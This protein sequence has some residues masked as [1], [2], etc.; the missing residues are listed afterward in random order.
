MN[1]VHVVVP[2]GIDDPRRPSGGNVYDRHVCRGLAELGWSVR[3]HPVAG[4]WPWPDQAARSGLAEAL[5]AVPDRGLVLLDGLVASTVPD[6]L[7][8]HR[9]RLQLVVLLH[10][11]LGEGDL[12]ARRVERA[13]L[14]TA[15]AVVTP[16]RWARRWLLANYGLRPARVQVAE[17]GV[18]LP[19][20][21]P[22]TSRADSLLCVGAVTPH[23][24]HDVLVAALGELAGLPWRCVV[25]GALDA[26]PGFVDDLRRR[27]RQ[28]GIAARLDFPGPL[29]GAD[30]DAAYAGADVLVLASRAESYG[31][32]VAEALAYGLPVIATSVGGVPEALGRAADGRLPGL[33]VPADDAPA[34][35][36]A[37]R[38]FLTD[39]SLRG[40]LRQAAA[41]RRRRLPQ[42]SHTATRVARALTAA[43]RA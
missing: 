16:S 29:T 22:G 38:D 43:A 41:D 18:E 28:H 5:A 26:A 27:A 40:S 39:G 31:M 30:L 32:V 3:E 21:A 7:Q 33:L 14:A 36:A 35:A 15:A 11:P 19:A 8:P 9:S 1:A 13:A 37:V 10:M 34:L 4:P 23:K 6:I 24:G 42:W 2:A 12:R 20:T 17:P 25:A